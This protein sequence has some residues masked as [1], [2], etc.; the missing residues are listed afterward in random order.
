MSDAYDVKVSLSLSIART[1]HHRLP[2][3][4]GRRHERAITVVC[5]SL[6]GSSPAAV[7]T[8]EMASTA[9]TV[10]LPGECDVRYA[11]VLEARATLLSGEPISAFLVIQ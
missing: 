7:G 4:L 3:S 11:G 8:L 2:S 10:M 9:M 1:T 6:A 5:V